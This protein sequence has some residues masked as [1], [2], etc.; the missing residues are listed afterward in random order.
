MSARSSAADVN[1]CTG[2][3]NPDGTDRLTAAG[4]SGNIQMLKKESIITGGILRNMKQRRLNTST[5][6]KKKKY[7]A[8]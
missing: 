3:I 7:I 2:T 4:V 5:F 6:W 8:V 1:G